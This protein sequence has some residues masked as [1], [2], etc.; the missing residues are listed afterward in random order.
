MKAMMPKPTKCKFCKKDV[1]YCL[2]LGRVFETDGTTFHV[3]NCERRKKFFKAES[4]V[5]GQ[6]ESQNIVPTLV[7]RAALVLG[8]PDDGLLPGLHKPHQFCQRPNVVGKPR[9]HRGRNPERL[10]D[11]AVVVVDGGFRIK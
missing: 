7:V 3:E 8:G 11:S 6:S 9:L 4:A 10:V 2:A 5:V 1:L